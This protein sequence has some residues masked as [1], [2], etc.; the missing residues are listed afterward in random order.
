M[1]LPDAQC[2]DFQ[3]ESRRDLTRFS[4]ETQSNRHQPKTHLQPRTWLNLLNSPR[5]WRAD[6]N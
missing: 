2:R 3:I 4:S 1:Y 6:A 5:T